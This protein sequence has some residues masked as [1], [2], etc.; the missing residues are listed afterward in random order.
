MHLKNLLKLFFFAVFCLALHPAMAQNKVITGKVTDAKDGSTL[1]GVAIVASGTSIGGATD[2]NGNFRISVPSNTTT[3][4]FTYL[5]YSRKEVAVTGDVVNVSME[6]TNTSLNEVLVVGFGTVRKKDATGA[7]VKVSSGDFVQGVTTNPLQQLQG[8]APGVV[9]TTFDGDPNSNPTV[10]IRGTAS[11]SGGNDP[12][13]VIDGIEGA[14]IRSVSPNDIESFDVLKD[15][16]AAAIYGSR[17][18]GGVILITTKTGKAGKAQVDVN[19][20]VA[21]ESP[22]KL[23]EFADRNLYLQLYQQVK[24]TAMPTGTT[25]TSDQ[26][27]N[28]NWFK[29]ITR[30]AFT[31]NENVA[32]SGGSEKGHYRGS[33]SYIDQQGIAYNYR[34]DLNARLNLD[35]KALNDKLLIT[36]NIS[37]SHTQSKFVETPGQNGGD[38]NVFLNALSVPSVISPYNLAGVAND[39]ALNPNNYQ[40]ISNTQEANPLPLLFYTQNR[41]TISRINGNL[42]LDY[43]LT[44]EITLSPFAN[45]TRDNGYGYIYYPPGPLVKPI[46]DQFGYTPQ[47]TSTGDIDRQST[48]ATTSTFGGYANYKGVF[49][50]SRLNVT[51]GAERYQTNY[52]GLRVGAHDFANINLPNENIGAANAIT[53]KDIASYDNG[54]ILNSIFGRIEYNY[55]DKYYITGNA[56]YDHSN[57]LGINNQGQ[58]F[59][60]GSVAWNIGSEEFLKD[61]R[62]LTSLKLRAG[63]GQ[64]GNQ[65]AISPY[66]SQ[67]L[68]GS[69]GT[70]YYDGTSGQFLS[71]NFAVQNAN[72]DLR[73]EVVSTTNFGADFSL[74]NGRLNGSIEVFDRKTDHLLFNYT[75]PTGSQ[76]FVNNILANI[77]SLDNRGF[78]FNVN[79]KI[80]ARKDFTWNAAVNFGLVRNK[81]TNLSGSLNGTNFNVTQTYTNGGT[82]GLGIS[83]QVSQIGYLKVGMP[84]G[85]LLLPEYAGQD[86]QGRQLFWKYGANG[87]RTAVTDL[88]TLN[89]ADDGST[90]DRKFYTTDPKFTY[91]INNS[92]TY[93]NWDLNIFLRGQY[94]SKAFNETYMDYTDLDKVG[95]YGILKDAAKYNITSP[96][97]PST[98]WL[99]STSFLKVQSANLGYTFGIAPNNYISRI[100]VYVAGNNIYTFTPY[101]GLDPE[102]FTSG[103]YAGIDRRQNY[104]RPRQFS[105][106][107][108]FTLK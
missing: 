11:L 83:G 25:T 12:L 105:F 62:W 94:G 21:T 99:Q 82:G 100:H 23:P 39:P 3:L 40:S 96:A 72:A 6:S 33:I 10:R 87:T 88:S 64:V 34:K 63:Y 69:T 98:F 102:V 48:M 101:K 44:K 26:G 86:A 58:V 17:A 55:N 20:Y 75:V 14:D 81:I 32:I 35:Q 30:T 68:F 92:F 79:G 76:F 43:N 89:Y 57:K 7:V 78:E 54:Y 108:N 51:A 1:P 16:S 59:P 38:N 27:A 2:V 70:L 53:N 46:A 28:T 103:I 84:I 74:F 47:L 104:P 29:L 42:R 61:T 50:K 80:I 107:V 77:G 36:M 66:N 67:F 31:H 71:R 97:Q 45:A 4:V 41:N 106:G 73:W 9:I 95:V 24:G 22:L 56:R 49:G 8:K 15:A 91:S 37:G 18:A 5:G 85:T 60:S 93:K 65:D 13:Y 19:S 52:Q 90:Q